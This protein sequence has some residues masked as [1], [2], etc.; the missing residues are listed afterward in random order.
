MIPADLILFPQCQY[1]VS[2]TNGNGGSKPI[3]PAQGGLLDILS[4]T[5]EAS[6]F[7]S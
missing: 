1:E 7:R 3:E 4:K 5:G 2:R 6:G